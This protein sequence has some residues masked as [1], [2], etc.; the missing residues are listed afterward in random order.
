MSD[1]KA[2]AVKL[3]NSIHDW[4]ADEGM[5]DATML[6]VAL[7]ANMNATLTLVEATEK[8]AEQARIAN[9]IAY[10][11]HRLDHPNAVD[12]RTAPLMKILA[13]LDLE[14]RVGLGL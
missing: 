8:V 6:A 11:G 12:V 9:L 5:T 13:G 14:I 1:H 10:A 4:Q 3:M 7:E 2:E